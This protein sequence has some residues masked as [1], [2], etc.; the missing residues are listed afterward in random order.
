MGRLRY[1]AR[2]TG[3]SRRDLAA[4]LAVKHSG[5][6]GRAKQL[7]PIRDGPGDR[8]QKA[9]SK[10]LDV[11]MRRRTSVGMGCRTSHG[12]RSYAGQPIQWPNSSWAAC[13]GFRAYF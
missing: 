5:I 4:V 6:D 3:C 11:E 13:Y 10:R 7:I 9:E 1:G 2:R 8:T 12:S